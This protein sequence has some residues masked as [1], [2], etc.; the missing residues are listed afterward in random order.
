M[1]DQLVFPTKTAPAAAYAR[2]PGH[3]LDKE[4][5]FAAILE[6]EKKQLKKDRIVSECPYCRASG[7]MTVKDYTQRGVKVSCCRCGKS[8]WVGRGKQ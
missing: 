7:P 8:F 2:Q 5:A 6:K 3:G 1:I 4:D